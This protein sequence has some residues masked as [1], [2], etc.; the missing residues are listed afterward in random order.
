MNAAEARQ[1]MAARDRTGVV[2]GEAFMVQTHPQWIRM[3]ELVRSG[4]IGQLRSAIGA[5]GYFNADPANV[6]NMRRY[7]GGGAD[8]YRL[9]SHQDVAHGIRGGAAARLGHDGARRELT[10]WTC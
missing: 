8:G 2:I 4:R 6:R 10:E 1:L 3:V 5:F 7:G 9:L